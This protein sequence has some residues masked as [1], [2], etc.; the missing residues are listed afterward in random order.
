MKQPHIFWRWLKTIFFITR[1]DR[2]SAQLLLSPEH[3]FENMSRTL[4][5]TC[6]VVAECMTVDSVTVS[7]CTCQIENQTH[8]RRAEA[9]LYD[10][11]AVYNYIHGK[12]CRFLLNMYCTVQIRHPPNRG[13]SFCLVACPPGSRS[14]ALPPPK[15]FECC[16]PCS[17]LQMR[18]RRWMKS[19]VLPSDDA[20]CPTKR[21]E[22]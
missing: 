14:P 13:R 22:L 5:L 17:P 3:W 10:S 2:L 4:L 18:S 19:H 21:D 20:R 16:N 9:C 8:L 1:R 15:G 12:Y 7:I 6:Q 11:N